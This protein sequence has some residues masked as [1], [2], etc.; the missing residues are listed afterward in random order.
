MESNLAG[1]NFNFLFSNICRVLQFNFFAKLK[2]YFL[3]IIS[4][5][6]FKFK[7]DKN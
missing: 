6:D 2:K 7:F 1:Y 5:Q 4:E 3:K